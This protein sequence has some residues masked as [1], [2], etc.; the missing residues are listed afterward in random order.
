ML[1]VVAL[2]VLMSEP[3]VATAH[4]KGKR[5]LRIVATEI[6]SEFLDLGV[7]GPSLGDELVFSETLFL[8]GRAVGVSGVVCTAT[9]RTSL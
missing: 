3:A 8:R 4:G 7:P 2:G 6:Q 9:G 1:A 5:A